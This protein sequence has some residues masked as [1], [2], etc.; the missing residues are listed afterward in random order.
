MELELHIGGKTISGWKAIEYTSSLDRLG[1]ELRCSHADLWG[2]DISSAL[3]AASI[4]YGVPITIGAP[5]ELYAGT[6]LFTGFVSGR[7]IVH[8][9]G[10]KQVEISCSAS[11]GSLVDCTTPA[12]HHRNISVLDLAK[13]LCDPFGITVKS[14]VN[15]GAVLPEWICEADGTTVADHLMRAAA[16]RGLL[17]QTDA[18]GNL[19]I[20]QASAR[21]I[22]TRLEVG[23]NIL[24]GSS[25]Y[26]SRE[27][28]SE[29]TAVSQSSTN[30]NWFGDSAAAIS[31]TVKDSTVQLYRP[32]TFVTEN[33]ETKA[34]LQAR[35]QWR[36]NRARG[37]SAR[38]SCDVVGWVDNSGALWQPNCIVAVRDAIA[39]IDDDLLLVST[40]LS[41]NEQGQIASLEFAGIGSYSPEPYTPKKKK[42]SLW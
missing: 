20:M 22:T 35:A 24:S 15:V 25:E 3:Q 6:K 18:D 10:S 28:Y 21:K 17:L 36:L 40:R 30:D 1:Q 34:A 41:S 33:P 38:Y 26:D 27:R 5:V 14:L 7:R 11:T 39:E 29:Y 16:M 31:A 19:V 2:S 42:E 32:T 8:T 9:A 37:K 13:K 4:G 12:K 23:A